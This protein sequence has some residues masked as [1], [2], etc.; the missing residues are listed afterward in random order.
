MKV[1]AIETSGVTGS[2]ALLEET[3]VVAECRLDSSHRSAQSLLP[4]IDSQL[5]SAGWLPGDIQLVAVAQGPGSF[6]GLRVGVT[7]GKTLAYAVGAQ[8]IGVNTLR[9][10]AHQAPRDPQRVNA[11]I[12]AH[13]GQVFSAFFSAAPDARWDEESPTQIM[14]D[15]L[16]LQECRVDTLVSGAGLKKLG[17]RLPAGIRV[18]AEP[19]WTPTAAVLGRLGYAD[20]CGGRRDDIWQFVPQYFRKSAAEE[21]REPSEN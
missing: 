1:L 9:I 8:L 3:N 13:R 19:L 11:V 10:I 16:W 2:A 5:K 14:D 4:A 15:E 21:K 20:F 7:A 17:P 12:D 6:T 18:A